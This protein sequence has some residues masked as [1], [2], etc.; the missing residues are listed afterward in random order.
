MDVF[1]VVGV[2]FDG[3]QDFLSRLFE[4]Q[5]KL[6]ISFER[7][8]DNLYDKN[9]INVMVD[10][11]GEL[12]RIGYIPKTHN[13]KFTEHL[14]VLHSYRILDFGPRYSKGLELYVK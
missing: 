9:A 5:E 11:N 14:P 1:R 3:R 6:K 8:P 4:T 10:I 7:E 12:F 13:V 2:L